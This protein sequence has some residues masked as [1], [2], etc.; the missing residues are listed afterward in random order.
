MI[1]VTNANLH[2][3]NTA[4]EVDH[5]AEL[6]V[7][8]SFWD[9]PTSSSCVS[10]TLVDFQNRLNGVYSSKHVNGQVEHEVDMAAFIFHESL[11]NSHTGHFNS[12]RGNELSSLIS[13]RHTN[14]E[15]EISGSRIMNIST[16]KDFFWPGFSVQTGKVC[17]F[18]KFSICFLF[19]ANPSFIGLF[20]ALLAYRLIT[21]FSAPCPF[22]E[23]E[24]MQPEN[25]FFLYKQFFFS[26]WLPCFQLWCLTK[27]FE[28]KKRLFLLIE[29]SGPA[30]EARRS[31]SIRFASKSQTWVKKDP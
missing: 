15:T 5:M 6:G 28:L 7:I 26:I 10:N 31:Y 21:L 16:H 19:L 14:C 23:K 12:V 24:Q 11:W 25:P 2:L 18:Q 17:L 22:W 8:L 27:V 1:C 13:Y 20:P 4:V 3:I 29:V 30:T 9:P